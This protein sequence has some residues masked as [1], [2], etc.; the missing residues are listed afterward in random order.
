VWY[1]GV[2]APLDIVSLSEQALLYDAGLAL[3]RAAEQLWFGEGS[4][5]ETVGSSPVGNRMSRRYQY[6]PSEF[7]MR[8]NRALGFGIGIL[9]LLWLMPTVFVGLEASLLKF[10]QTANRILDASQAVVDKAGL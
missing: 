3:N 4:D 10:F 2:G 7:I 6:F 1:V 9:I 5:R 8:I